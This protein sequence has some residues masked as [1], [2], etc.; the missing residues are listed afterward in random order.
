MT[1]GRGV[2]ESRG[3]AIGVGCVAVAFACLGLLVLSVGRAVALTDSELLVKEFGSQGE[4]A[5]QM[6]SVG[7]GSADPVTGHIFVGDALANRVS[8]FTPWGEFV[9]AFGWD[10]APGPV[11]EQQE[12]RVL[13]AGGQFRLSFEGE[14]TS[15]LPFDASATE[16]ADALDSL[17]AIG[18]TGGT[19]GISERTGVPASGTPFVYVV[20]FRGSLAGIDVP[21]LV[22]GDG[23]EP[24]GGGM[25]ETSAKIRTRADGSAGGTG[26]ESCTQESGCRAGS[27]GTGAGQF[28]I[29]QGAAL[30]YPTAPAVGSDGSIYIREAYGES[31]FRNFRVQK[32][33]SAGRFVLMFGG[34]VDKTRVALREE[35]E[36][37]SEP[38]TVT[39]EEENVCTAASGDDCGAG[40]PGTGRGQFAEGNVFSAPRT[41][42][43]LGPGGGPLFAGD[44][45]RV[46]RFNLSGEYESE[47][48]VAGQIA[49]LG[50][51]P[52]SGD[53]YTTHP[54]A[55]SVFPQPDVHR[56]NGNSGAELAALATRTPALSLTVGPDGQVYVLAKGETF[57]IETENIPDRILQFGPDGKESGAAFG[58]P[59]PKSATELIGVGSNSIGDVFV[60][61]QC[62]SIPNPNHVA[63]YGPPPVQF[64][65]PP[66]VPPKIV[67]Q[68]ST[69]VGSE[70]AEVRANINPEFWADTRF[71]VEYGTAP[72]FEGGCKVAPAPP[73]ELLTEA[74]TSSAVTSAPVVLKGLMPA[75]TYHYRVVAESGGGGPVAG[76]HERT[77]LEAEA[78]FTTRRG[79]P[80]RPD[81]RAYEL[82]SPSQ[83]N[84]AE[85]GV[86][87][88]AGGGAI[89]LPSPSGEAI[90]YS[91]FTAFGHPEGAFGVSQYVSRR[92]D[93][94]W[95]TRNLNLFGFSNRF[96]GAPYLGFS[97]DLGFAAGT[98]FEPPLTGDA[99]PGF[100]TLYWRNTS[101]GALV[102]M[103]TVEPT[104]IG[105][106]PYCVT[107]AGANQSGDRVFFAAN[108]S[109]PGDPA[110]KGVSL[111]EWGAGQGTRLVSVFSGE[112]PAAPQTETGFGP[113]YSECDLRTDMLHNAV[114]DDGEI[115]Y[116]TYRPSSGPSSLMAR[117]G[118]ATSVRIDATQGGAGPAGGGVFQG[119]S[120]DGT[121]SFFSS[122][123]ALTPDA[124][125][126]I[127]LYRYDFNARAGSRLTDLTPGTAAADV[128]GALGAGADGN[129]IYFAAG[130]ALAN[131]AS[132]QS[133]C[134][135]SAGGGCNLYRW[136]KG[137]GLTFIASLTGSDKSDWAAG[138]GRTNPNELTAA[139]SPDGGHLAFLSIL[140]LTGFDN[141][142]QGT[143][144]A[145]IEI[146]EDEGKEKKRLN[147]NSCASEVYLY[148]AATEGLS[149]ASCSST[150][151][152]PTGQS[153]LPT[154]TNPFEGP[155]YLSADG[156]RLFFTTV[157]NLDP[158]DRN[159]Q[160]DVYEFERPGSGSCTASSPTYNPVQRGCQWL[161]SEGQSTA[162]TALLGASASG[163]DVFFATRSRLVGA[164]K[165]ERYD[166]YDY[167]EGGG[168]PETPEAPDCKGEE[169]RPESPTASPGAA[170]P[171][172]PGFVGPGNIKP[173]RC[174]K[175]T[176]RVVKKGVVHC[177]KR[178]RRHH[179]AHHHKRSH[180]HKKAKKHG[181]KQAKRPH[182]GGNL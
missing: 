95:S 169:C 124:A 85:V 14:E 72:C 23:T 131:G 159:E 83:K 60:S 32:F 44:N 50:I 26:L 93:S 9:K 42:L 179:R 16:V 107:F 164:D 51:D 25:P 172:T 39:E 53:F 8:E 113:G 62:C 140:P 54:A 144:S 134:A 24:L 141:N 61:E 5:G 49:S 2:F 98:S 170:K 65:A 97:R 12:V 11:N 145:C 115:A 158:A 121:V 130:G 147:P 43:V 45:G 173:R 114:S 77:G 89:R 122:A 76:L 171:A 106:G 7:I 146:E 22:A 143:S 37:N 91:S 168:F 68:F 84:S 59:D 148:D 163:R 13:A 128:I 58:S 56:L 142:L 47:V 92:T 165:D 127:N 118:G 41:S 109:F 119:A 34:E 151:Q 155:G 67:E 15:D 86:D 87:T 149:C 10:V 27:R 94:G 18:G 133:E 48:P 46:Q 52:P 101:S 100:E 17:P 80:D 166:V 69:E 182:R 55:G 126:G 74:V 96:R 154:W 157:D 167:R 117:I 75:T 123:N 4:A 125:P 110:G 1:A 38:V 81:L 35:E 156:R 78:T 31:P 21:Q 180:H 79:S 40:V 132:P 178:H 82:V 90:T 102:A 105:S 99:I 150:G 28:A 120:D 162:P 36:A 108:G 152:R 181:G 103:N 6:K 139:V 63:I 161:V 153:S 66:S 111:Y 33:D 135:A 71:Y 129:S 160:P 19:V 70:T 20:A 57:G 30:R 88:P 177:K 112:T 64:E 138:S 175:G 73:G 104:V 116:W 136:A 29:L 174:R 137:Q 176:H 3:V